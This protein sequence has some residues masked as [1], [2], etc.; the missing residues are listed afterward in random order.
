MRRR[1]RARDADKRRELEKRYSTSR[2]S[3]SREAM[4][5]VCRE[6]GIS[7]K[8]RQQGLDITAGA[9]TSIIARGI[10]NEGEFPRG[11]RRDIS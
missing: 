5:E 11:T 8:D 4:T 6:F 3:A 7:R 1:I 9:E 10:L 2:S